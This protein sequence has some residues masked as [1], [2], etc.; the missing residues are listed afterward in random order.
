MFFKR[1]QSIPKKPDGSETSKWLTFMYILALSIIALVT[2]FSQGLI[3]EYLSNQVK[4]S[5][6]INISARLRTYSQV[7]SKTALLIERGSNVDTNRKEFLNTLKQLQKSH[8]GL[9][10]GS[11][12]FDIPT[13]DRADLEQ[14]YGIIDG[15]YKKII[16]AS[17]SLIKEM[18]Q[19]TPRQEI[20]SKYV[21]TI[22]SYEQSYLLGMELIVFDYDRFSRNSVKNLK[23]IEY[24]LSGFILL[25]LVMEFVFIF[26]PISRK[27][28]KSMHSLQ[29]SE[30]KQKKLLEKMKSANLVLENSH[31]ELRE[32]DFALEKANYLVKTDTAGNILYANDK[33]AHVSKYPASELVGRPIFYNN[34]G[35]QESVVY[36]HIRDENRRREV[37]QGE[38]FDHASDG[39]G[40]WLDVT[41]MPVF[42]N[43]GEIYQY[44]VIGTD[45]TK[46]KKT[47]RELRLLMEEKL[48]N[49]KDE[50]KTRSYSIITGQEKE[51]KR[52]SKEI[53][54]GIGQM[55]TSMR[56]RL[57][58]VVSQ[59]PSVAQDLT[60]IHGLLQSIISETRRIC[61]NLLPN[62]LHDFGLRAAVNDLVKS[63]RE[64]TNLK[65]DLEE[66]LLLEYVDKEIEIGIFRIV[67]EALNNV[68][69]HSKALQLSIKIQNDHKRL[70]LYIEDNG[71]GFSYNENELFVKEHKTKN[72]GLR[73][74]KE[75]AELLGGDLK[76][77]S[78][79]N[80]GTSVQLTIFL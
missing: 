63:M 41:L 73:N 27:V 69:K 47:E 16:E 29:L 75:R 5:R 39:T 76:I 71:K 62:V 6:L 49:Q 40:F 50:Q 20:V 19:E 57:E 38:I 32:R 15:P 66:N 28:K 11:T 2:V 14:M 72:N 24:Y 74:M 31:R 55:L 30:E 43:M 79:K 9:I 65:V 34:M 68:M 44:L 36:G 7:L 52:V 61:S 58:M 21:N 80:I 78:T 33:Y 26:Y 45:V 48:K 18:Y 13:N 35:S 8:N 12:F 51:R 59:H 37:W 64:S 4:D 1:Q 53:H 42:N 22:L 77:T 23:K 10:S 25:M 3:Q 67:Q 54:D 56:M 60:D 17:D 70:D 46:R